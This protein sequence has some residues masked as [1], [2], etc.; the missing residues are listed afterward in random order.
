M[1]G[2]GDPAFED[3]EKGLGVV[4]R[5]CVFPELI[6]VLAAGV[7]DGAMLFELATELVCT[8]LLW[9]SLDISAPIK[10][11]LMPLS[12]ASLHHW[13]TISSLSRLQLPAIRSQLT[14]ASCFMTERIER[15]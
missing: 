10:S 5:H 1:V 14:N 4:C 11:K 6:G 3:A 9:R 7:I 12:S 15:I 2:S 13:K 8:S